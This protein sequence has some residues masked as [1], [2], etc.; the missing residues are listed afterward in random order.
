MKIDPERTIT[1]TL[2]FGMIEQLKRAKPVLA[3]FRDEKEIRLVMEII[4]AIY[5]GAVEYIRE[6]EGELGNLLSSDTD[7]DDFFLIEDDEEDKTN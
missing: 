2:P 7:D 6:E 4:D 3:M 5:T 1:I